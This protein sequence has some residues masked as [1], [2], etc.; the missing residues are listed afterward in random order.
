VVNSAAFGIPPLLLPWF[1]I[2]TLIWLGIPALVARDAQRHGERAI[3]WWLL[4][5]FGG[6]VVVIAWLV[7]RRRLPIEGPA[8][9]LIRTWLIPAAAVSLAAFTAL[10]II[11]ATRPS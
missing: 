8:T 6:L 5:F 7:I 11:E 2:F 9:S 4:T 1:F 10:V 3:V